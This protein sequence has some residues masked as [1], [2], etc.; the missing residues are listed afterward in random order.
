[1]LNFFGRDVNI[2]IQN[3]SK[4]YLSIRARHILHIEMQLNGKRIV[5]SS[6]SVCLSPFLAFIFTFV[7]TTVSNTWSLAG[8]RAPA[9][10]RKAPTRGAAQTVA[11]ER[12]YRVA[13]F[14]LER[15]FSLYTESHELLPTRMRWK[16]AT[17]RRLI[18]L[19]QWNR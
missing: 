11:I 1:M 6:L 4:N 10:D 9:I 15:A 13:L 5:F 17:D 18:T 14:E 2:P 19:S 12:A 8:T 3:P 7:S 16:G